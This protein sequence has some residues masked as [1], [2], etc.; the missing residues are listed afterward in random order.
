MIRLPRFRKPRFDRERLLLTLDIVKFLMLLI[1]ALAFVNFNA[2]LSQQ[3]AAT[4]VIASNGQAELE[5]IKRLGQQNY[6]LSQQNKQ[7]YQQNQDYQKCNFLAFAKFTRTGVPIQDSEI[8]TCDLSAQNL[9]ASGGSTG[10]TKS[11]PVTPTTPPQ[12]S[13]Q[14]QET[15]PKNSGSDN[16]TQPKKKPSH[17]LACRLTLGLLG[18]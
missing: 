3:V 11:N 2:K 16:N 10:S 12:T 1:L 17:P 5:Q 8:N 6:N 15:Q 9:S 7:L 4:K 13:P 18:C 14:P